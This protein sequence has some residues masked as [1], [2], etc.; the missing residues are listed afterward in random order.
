M[1]HDPPTISAG[2]TCQSTRR[3]Q[4]TLRAG[5]A[6]HMHRRIPCSCSIHL[7][8]FSYIFFRLHDSWHA[9]PPCASLSE[10]RR[11]WQFPRSEGGDC[12]WSPWRLSGMHAALFMPF[13]M[14]MQH[15]MRVTPSRPRARPGSSLL[16]G[17]GAH[18]MHV[19]ACTLFWMT[20]NI[21]SDIHAACH[22]ARTRIVLAWDR[23]R[24]RSGLAAA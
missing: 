5:G 14:R 8:A 15:A 22:A 2:K 3:A 10:N 13:F 6:C 9:Q 16:G 20:C 19:Y 17:T 1:V 11:F 4:K 23:S 7:H 24:P 21:V 12:R 18:S